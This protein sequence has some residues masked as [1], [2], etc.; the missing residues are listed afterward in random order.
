MPIQQTIL[1][2]FV[3]SPSDVPE[4]RKLLGNVILELNR[5]WADSLGLAFRL[6]NWEC[7]VAPGYG[8]EPQAVINSQIPSQYDVFVGIFWGRLGS[9]TKN[10]SSGTVEEFERAIAR[11]K[12]TGMPEI[13]VYFKDAPIPPSKIDPVQLQKLLNF[14]GGLGEQGVLHF[15]FEDQNGFEASLRSHLS[16]MARKHSAGAQ[17]AESSQLAV[18]SIQI[19]ASALTD[20]E[21]LG[22]LDY[23]DIYVSENR[24]MISC[25]DKINTLTLEIGARLEKRAEQMRTVE[26]SSGKVKKFML[27]GAADMNSYSKELD[28]QLEI[29]KLSKVQ[30]FDALSKSVALHNEII[31]KD[32]NLLTLQETLKN[33]L[34]AIVTSKEGVMGMRDAAASLPRMIKEVTQSKRR[35]VESLD[36]F[37]AEI[38]STLATATNIVESIEQMV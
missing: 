9:P 13:M 19:D 17:S 28:G 32:D 2:V 7:D 22:Y 6:Y 11:H 38:D 15:T 20:D 21:D 23:I 35:M 5:T 10:Y 8:E 24:K 4:E 33:L 31:G 16:A 34:P 30:A 36:S 27:M 3:A 14:K 18:T 12:T 37:L 29:Y 1:Q 25:L 26:E